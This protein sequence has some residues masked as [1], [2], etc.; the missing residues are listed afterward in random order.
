MARYLIFPYWD[1]VQW[2]F[3]DPSREISQEPFICGSN[4]VLT[5]LVNE[6]QIP[7]AETDGFALI[8]GDEPIGD[9]QTVL[10]LVCRENEG[11]RYATTVNG[12][13]MT[14][15]LCPQFWRYFDEA[16]ER[17]YLA[18]AACGEES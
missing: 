1:G 8:F 7:S 6:R 10:H 2:V 12:Q 3:D 18:L 14:G 16:P 13:Q 9:G 11:V 17:I 5:A 4:E 15:W